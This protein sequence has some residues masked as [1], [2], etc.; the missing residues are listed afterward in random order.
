MN[1]LFLYHPTSGKG[2]VAKK[3]G[4]IERT[5]RSHVDGVD[6]I[7]RFSGDSGSAD[8]EQVCYILR[9]GGRWYVVGCDFNYDE[10]QE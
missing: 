9:Q 10:T 7:A 1:C 3:I 4:Y 5:L 2:K 6:I 8:I